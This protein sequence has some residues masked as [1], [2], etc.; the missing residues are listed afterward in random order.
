MVPR[1]LE[2]P[3][4]PPTRTSHNLFFAL[5]PS[6]AVRAAIAA[7]ARQLRSELAPTG[8][9]LAPRR[10]HMTLH[11]LGNHAALPAE[12]VARALAAGDAV[13]ISPFEF[14]LDIAGSFRNR[15]IPWWF[16]SNEA[17]SELHDVSA[18]L[19]SAFPPQGVEAV[20][21]SEFVPHVT[22]L[23]DARIPLARRAIAA[24]DWPVD[25]FVL[26][27]SRLGADPDYSILRRWSLMRR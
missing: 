2:P 11:F 7:A 16:G 1:I 12:L 22:V 21:E 24:I 23:R 17:P 3:G 6:D 19:A 4:S 20:G 13:N 14:A 25:D 27:D 8:R 5:W 9:W 15:T 10:Y 18:A 26:V